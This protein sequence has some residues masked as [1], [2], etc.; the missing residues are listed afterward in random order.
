MSN[1]YL[2]S[3]PESD[4]AVLTSEV[5]PEENFSYSHL[6]SS[7]PRDFCQWNIGL[8]S[9]RFQI[10]FQ[11]PVAFNFCGLFYTNFRPGQNWIVYLLDDS[12][13]VIYNSGFL[14][15]NPEADWN[16]SHL[17]HVLNS[18]VSCSR[19]I[20][21]I[22]FLAG[23]IDHLRVGRLMAGNAFNPDRSVKLGMRLG[24]ID[25]TLTAESTA[26]TFKRPGK[27][28]RKLTSTFETRN[29]AEAY[30]I[31]LALQ[32]QI[33]ASR[34]M[35]VIHDARSRVVDR[36]LYGHLEQ[37]EIVHNQYVPSFSGNSYAINHEF[38]EMEHP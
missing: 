6:K 17:L 29:E 10:D 12:D 28:K 2:M 21:Y 4:D 8:T 11:S 16:R 9:T 18:P 3:A 33:G 22:H 32:R 19:C 34:E 20:V 24:Y 26:S 25:K 30:G 23:G 37:S 5:L 38:T 14:L 36:L 31:H 7:Q 15:H 13:Q 35:A 1:Y 27:L